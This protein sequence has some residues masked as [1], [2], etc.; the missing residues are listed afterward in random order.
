MLK[1]VAA[2]ITAVLV[3][4]AAT[5]F[6]GGGQCSGGGNAS[7][8][9]SGACLQRSATGAVTVANVMPGSAAARAGLRTGDVVTA[10]NGHALGEGSSCAGHADCSVG[11]VMTYT[12]QRG[13]STRAVRVKLQ[14]MPENAAQ[15]FA[16]RDASFDPELAA[17]II[18]SAD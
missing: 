8:A 17:L 6:A 7:A 2:S 13:H 16:H 14:R 18:A 15:R 11:S 10:L 9:W 5:A 12:V 4:G 3:L 1:R